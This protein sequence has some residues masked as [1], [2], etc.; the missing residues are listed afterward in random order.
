ML[1]HDFDP[2]EAQTILADF[3]RQANEGQ[4]LYATRN[5][6]KA[7][8]LRARFLQMKQSAGSAGSAMK[9]KASFRRA[10]SAVAEDCRSCHSAYR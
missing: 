9:D 8:E 2:G 10:F 5:D 7:G 6:A 4:A 3:A 1:K